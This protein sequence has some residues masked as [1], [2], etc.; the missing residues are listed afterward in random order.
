M[1]KI[2]PLKLGQKKIPPKTLQSQPKAHGVGFK[3]NFWNTEAETAPLAQGIIGHY[4]G[5]RNTISKRFTWTCTCL[6]Q[7]G[8]GWR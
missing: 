6:N 4:L 5:P 8:A 2:P 1:I 7:T 3:E